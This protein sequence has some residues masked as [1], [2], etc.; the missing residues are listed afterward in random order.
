MATDLKTGRRRAT[1]SAAT[2]PGHMRRKS[3]AVIQPKST[4]TSDE[5]LQDFLDPTFDPATF[6]NS[7][8]PPLQQ[9]SIPGRTGDVAPLAELSTQAQTLISQLNV[10]TSRLSTTL[11]H[12]TDDILRSGSRLAYEVELL[13]GET[14]SLQ[15]TMNETLHD[16]IK[17][18][19]PEGLQE[20]I[21]AKYPAAAA[22]K[23]DRSAAPS[24]T[25]AAVTN[26]GANPDD[27]EFI[28]HLQTLTLVRARLDSVIKT[29]GDA[30]EFVFPPSEISVSSGFLS[31]SAPEPGS[32]QQSSEEKGKEVLNNIR[33]EISD[34]LNKSD[35]PVQGIEKAAQRIEQLKELNRVWK[36]T[37]EEKGRNKFIESLAKTVEDKHRDLMKEMEQ[38][39]EKTKVESRSRKGSVTRD[40]AATVVEDTKA[41]GGFGLISQLHKLRGGL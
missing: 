28:R 41:P 21:E 32:A 37:A 5:F 31:V 26:D 2:R 23:E 36:D 38:T 40:A 1:S 33:N 20:A 10:Q 29:F 34:L 19:V 17:K 30:M 11:T 4:H 3:R 22:A 24:T 15:E 7:T 12:L 14:L 9:R 35:D 39:K 6:L 16:D 18:F 13:R 8:L 27:P 25:A